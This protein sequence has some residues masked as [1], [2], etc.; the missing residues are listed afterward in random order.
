MSNTRLAIEQ[1]DHPSARPFQPMTP[2]YYCPPLAQQRE[3]ARK[4]APSLC[5]YLISWVA[6]ARAGEKR[7]NLSK[8]TLDAAGRS[9]PRPALDSELEDNVVES[10]CRTTHW[11]GFTI[12]YELKTLSWP[13]DTELVNIINRWSINLRSTLRPRA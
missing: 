1:A 5:T 11:E 2:L 8:F 7:S 12:A 10:L 13:S 6:A 4:Y 3:L 9:L